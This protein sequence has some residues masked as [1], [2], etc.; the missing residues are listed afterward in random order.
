MCLLFVYINSDPKEGDYKLILVNNRD[1]NYNRPTKPARFWDS[2][3]LGG[4]DMFA[5]REGGTW[6]GMDSERQHCLFAQYIAT[7]PGVLGFGNSVVEKPFKKVQRGKKKME[8]VVSCFGKRS[9]QKQLIHELFEITK[10]RE[11]NFPDDQLTYQGRQFSK[12]FLDEL[13]RIRVSCTSENIGT[14][15]PA[16]T[17]QPRKRKR[18]EILR[19]ITRA[20]TRPPPLS[21]RGRRE[22][23]LLPE[24]AP[25]SLER[26]RA[27]DAEQT[28]LR[29][30][31]LARLGPGGGAGPRDNPRFT[32]SPPAPGDRPALAC[33][34]PE[35]V[36][37]SFTVLEG[38]VVVLS[39]EEAGVRA[40]ADGSRLLLPEC[41]DGN[42]TATSDRCVD[43]PDLA[44]CDPAA[45]P[46]PPSGAVV[47]WEGVEG[48]VYG[49]ESGKSWASGRRAAL[50]QCLQGHWTPL[51]DACLSACPKDF[52]RAKKG[53]YCLH[54]STEA[55]AIGLP[56][57]ALSC[58]AMNSSLALIRDRSDLEGAD[59]ETF[60]Y[61]GHTF[62]GDPESRPSIPSLADLN[63]TDD[64]ELTPGHECVVV[65]GQG[66][67]RFQNCSDGL[68][69][70][71]CMYPAYCPVGYTLHLG[72]CYKVIPAASTFHD[73]Y[74]SCMKEG[75][76]LAVPENVN[77]LQFLT[78]LVMKTEQKPIE[79]PVKVMLGI[80]CPSPWQYSMDIPGYQYCQSLH[81]S[82]DILPEGEFSVNPSERQTKA[83]YAV[84]KHQGILDCWS[85]PESPRKHTTLSW[86]NSMDYETPAIY[87]LSQ[88]SARHPEVIDKNPERKLQ[89]R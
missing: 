24:R 40:W 88:G 36:A 49:C 74:E 29:H 5:G 20:L 86:N 50:V 71:S 32:P 6:L 14:S 73:S 34:P 30:V 82:L 81:S 13:C 28:S 45:T 51:D 27:G 35:G 39:C 89:K 53:A 62:R 66:T 70:Y 22:R 7:E 75:S 47:L 83:K 56:G 77:D 31:L 19:A 9:Y 65:S 41:V 8:E 44:A 48:V 11:T 21:P 72:L 37:E 15:F 4:A 76:D 2:G 38:G 55:H 57:A 25:N 26:E 12:D 52:Q 78:D 46:T 64:C 60:Y 58:G 43:E 85:A 1:E 33:E 18:H 63:C 61:T 23:E 17:A 84:C 87:Q 69:K 59:Q 42:W 54:F 10:D 67:Y 3:I 16:T 80:A 68:T 79:E